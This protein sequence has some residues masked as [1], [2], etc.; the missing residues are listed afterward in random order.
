AAGNPLA[1]TELPIAASG[2]KL[3]PT[4]GLEAF[5]LTARL[6]RAFAARLGDLNSDARALLLVAALDE[7]EPD[8][9]TA[10]AER[11]HGAAISPDGWAQAVG[12]GVGRARAAG[13]RFL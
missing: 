6:E 2:L 12:A 5:P 7:A 1:L 11:F 9:L 8:R 4:P 3:E 10:A 13:G